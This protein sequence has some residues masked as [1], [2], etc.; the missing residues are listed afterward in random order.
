M[1][2]PATPSTA[3]DRLDEAT[4]RDR[5]AQYLKEL[6]MM[7]VPGLTEEGVEAYL[8]YRHERPDS[9]ITTYEEGQIR[10]LLHR[11]VDPSRVPDPVAAEEHV[12]RLETFGATRLHLTNAQTYVAI[13]VTL[14]FL[15]VLVLLLLLL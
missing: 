11:Y 5:E 3:W 8:R 4:R 1:A 14:N 7:S 13:M 12:G 15:F 2:T 10:K 9:A 6:S